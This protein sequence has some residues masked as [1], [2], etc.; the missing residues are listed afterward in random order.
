MLYLQS[1]ALKSVRNELRDPKNMSLDTKIAFL[2]MLGIPSK[3]VR[4][5]LTKLAQLTFDPLPPPSVN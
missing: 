4:H 3:L 2:V 1:E 5:K